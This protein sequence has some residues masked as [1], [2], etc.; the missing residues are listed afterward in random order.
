MNK[1]KNRGITLIALIITII[2]LLIL[3]VITIQSVLGENGIIA[4]ANW[5]NFTTEFNSIDE[6]KN[7]YKLENEAKKY[8]VISNKTMHIEKSIKIATTNENI[9]INNSPYPI[10]DEKVT[11]YEESLINTIKYYENIDET[12]NNVDLYKVDLSK[13][14]INTKN[15][16]VI[17]VISG[18]LYKLKGIKYKGNIYH[19]PE[20]GLKDGQIVEEE[21]KLQI[22][23]ISLSKGKT[24]TLIAKFGKEIISNDKINWKSL[25]PSIVTI[26]ENGNVSAIE[27][28]KAQIKGK[29]KEDNTKEA[30]IEIN[31]TQII[32]NIYTKEDMEEFRYNVNSGSTYDGLTVK[33]MKN[34]DLKGDTQNNW[35]P[36]GNENNLFLGTFEGNN[37][38]VSGLYID[39]ESLSNQGLFGVTQNANL[40]NLKVTGNIKAGYQIGGIVGKADNTIIDNCEFRGKIT[41]VGDSGS[42]YSDVGGIVGVVD[43]LGG[44]I[45]NCKNYAQIDA[46][47]VDAGGIAGYLTWG[48]IENCK[49]YGIINGTIDSYGGIVGAI[50]NN[51]QYKDKE[52]RIN[53]CQNN[54]DINGVSEDSAYIGGICGWIK[55][56][57]TQINNCI[58]E[59]GADIICNG[60]VQTSGGIDSDCSIVGGIIGGTGAT[61]NN[62][63]IINCTNNAKIYAKGACVGGIA[64]WIMTGSIES[65]T[66]TGNIIGK[67]G[68]VAGISGYSSN[69]NKVRVNISKCFNSGK[70]ESE[71]EHENKFY[72]EVA[73]ISGGLL[74]NIESCVNIGEIYAETKDKNENSYAAGIV[75]WLASNYGTV[76]NCYNTGK[77]TS[78]YDTVGGIVGA[79]LGTASA[80]EIAYCYNIG[81]IEAPSYVGGII[82]WNK[83]GAKTVNNCYYLENKITFTNSDPVETNLGESANEDII[84]GI[85]TMETWK[86][87][88]VI[89]KKQNIN[90]GFPILNWQ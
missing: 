65:C 2:V 56:N 66:N 11:E 71:S 20:V 28:G 48:N 61:F 80:N 68:Q 17:N 89:D 22:E 69:N 60:Y 46:I 87:N 73:G 10:T 38:N 84:K 26:D 1:Q 51:G 45:T 62:K 24:K 36:I 85:I 49:N 18:N 41:S 83:N 52:I 39:A 72:G 67:M 13:L 59:N 75:S 3:A 16:Y 21:K 47:K 5:A 35:E 57:N 4:K 33:L 82:G 23:Q 32:Q 8:G 90:K 25:T 74:G 43:T 19:R 29:L 37:N 70:I 54:G 7:I 40:Q 15:E 9:Q 63:K 27:I 79:S 86:D 14:N 77:I 34:I 81:E 55:G 64:G 53:D 12:E 50:G 76:Y 42:F 78:K 88:F 30:I 44:T 58:N 31:V 6:G